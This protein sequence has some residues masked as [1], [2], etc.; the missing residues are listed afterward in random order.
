VESPTTPD[1]RCLF[2]L[3]RQ[4]QV[5]LREFVESDG[6]S[7]QRMLRALWLANRGEWEQA[8]ALAQAED[9]RDGAWVHAYLHR[10]EGE[11]S[12]A[13]YWYRGA[14]RPVQSGELKAE[15]ETIVMELLQRPC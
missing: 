4:L 8:H 11:T 6:Q 5:G 15:W 12:N 1:R 7:H 9:S 3:S 13:S 10:V 14:S 2:L